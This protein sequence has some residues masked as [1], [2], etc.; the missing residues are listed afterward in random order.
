MDLDLESLVPFGLLAAQFVC[1]I[2]MIGGAAGLAYFRLQARRR[3]WDAL[4]SSMGL[5]LEPGS[6]FT[7]PRVTGTYRRHMLTLDTF[8]RGSS[9]S[10]TTYTRIVVFVDNRA[11]L[12]LALYEEGV[13]SKIG[14]FFGQED[15]QIGEE[16]IDRRFIIK[17]RPETFAARL[18]TSIN[19]RSKLLQARSINV[20]VDGREL[21]YEQRGTETDADYLR[22][23]LDMLMDLAEFVERA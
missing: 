20:E 23:L 10:R 22:F 5:T 6:F 15:V 3:A 11:N 13:F 21:Y 12:Y 17:S 9:K 8:S 14:K 19:L 2:G 18:V 4:A 7:S 16:E 1:M